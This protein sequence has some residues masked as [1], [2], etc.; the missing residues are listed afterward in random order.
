M[1]RFTRNYLIILGV[2]ALI[3]L[4]AIFYES[5]KVWAL[6]GLLKDEAELAEYPYQFRVLDFNNG[7]ATVSTPRAANFNAFRALRILFPELARVS[8]DSPRLYEAQ[9]ELARVQSVAAEVVK[10]APDVERVAWHLDERWLR[11]NGINPDLL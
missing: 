2:I 3:V 11:N 9:Q 10:A 1:D 6:N 4:V 8:D 7:V 5:P